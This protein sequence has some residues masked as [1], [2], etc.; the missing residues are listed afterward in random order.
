MYK[1]SG[2]AGGPPPKLYKYAQQLQFII[3]H[4]GVREY[5]TF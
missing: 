4:F 1:R 3:P 2:V 5:V